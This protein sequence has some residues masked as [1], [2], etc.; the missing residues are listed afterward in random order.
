MM[1]DSQLAFGASGE[2]PFFTKANTLLLR[3]SRPICHAILTLFVFKA[4]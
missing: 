3:H 2:R 4:A 1:T